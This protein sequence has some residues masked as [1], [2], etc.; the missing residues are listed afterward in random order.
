MK[1]LSIADYLDHLGRPAGDKAPLR[2][3]GSPFLP[4]SLPAP[5]TAGPGAKPAF[6]RAMNAV[7]ETQAEAAPA[8]A[9][10]APKPVLLVSA[11]KQSP[12]AA[13]LVRAEDMSLKLAEAYARGRDEGLAE[14]RGEASDRHAAELAA[15]RELAETQQQEFRL[16]EYATLEGAIRSGLREIEDNIGAAVTRILAPFLSQQVVQRAADELAKAIARL[17]TS[18]SPGLIKIRGPER[19]LALLRQRIADLPVDVEYVEDDGVETVVE[20]R[21]TRIV[22]EL[23]PWAELLAS[24]EA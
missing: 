10:W 19:V 2:P 6:N 5:Q 4:R 20:A 23:R 3:E 14:A 22:A 11:G 18:N 13:E 17:S 15:A 21:T 24:F 7:V 1:P 8:R 16:N 9:P 12:P